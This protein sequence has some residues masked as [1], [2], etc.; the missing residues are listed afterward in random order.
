VDVGSSFLVIGLSELKYSTKDSSQS[1]DWIEILSIPECQLLARLTLPAEQSKELFCVKDSTV[2]FLRGFRQSLDVC[3]F[4]LL[5][6]LTKEK[7]DFLIKLCFADVVCL[8]FDGRYALVKTIDKVDRISVFDTHTN[9]CVVKGLPAAD[10]KLNELFRFPLSVSIEDHCNLSVINLKTGGR[11]QHFIHRE[12]TEANSEV[13]LLN[14]MLITESGLL[15][16]SRYEKFL[17]TDH[18][19]CFSQMIGFKLDDLK[20]GIY[21]PVTL[22]LRDTGPLFDGV[23][24]SNTQLATIYSAERKIQLFN[25]WS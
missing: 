1:S 8:R 11:S 20:Y 10:F 18:S 6:P 5:N 19:N 22:N 16:V 17:R 3:E 2:I 12:R 4:I 21:A 23:H 25:F 14:R 13:G 7:R 15:L 24:A 9:Q